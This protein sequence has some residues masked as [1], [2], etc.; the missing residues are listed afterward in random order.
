[1][2]KYRNKIIKE[3]TFI[4]LTFVVNNRHW[5]FDEVHP[6]FTIA[7]ASIQKSNPGPNGKIP[8]RGPYPDARSFDE[9]VSADPHEFDVES[10]KNWGGSAK[11]PLLPASPVSVSAFNKMDEM[12]RLS[13]EESWYAVPYQELNATQD[14]KKDDGTN[15][16]HTTDNPPEDNYWPVYK[17][18]SYDIWDPDRGVYY[19]WA[20]PETVTEYLHDSRASSYRYAGSRSPFS[21]MSQEWIES[22]DTLPCLSARITFRDVSRHTDSRTVR[23]ALIPPKTPVVHNS[24]T[25]IW[26]SGE[27]ADEA[28]LLGVLCSIP[29]DWYS[30]RF[31][32]N[33]VTFGVFNN[34]PIPRPGR[35]NP[36]RER[37]VELSGRLAAVDDRYAEWAEAVGVDCGPIQNNSKQEKIYELDA[38]VAH[39]Y[40]LSREHVEVIFETFHDGWD[41]EERLE[42]VLDYYADWADRLDLDHADREAERAAGTRNDD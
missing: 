17:G 26:P 2:E 34:L 14:K 12:N 36:L 19:G 32:E 5:M 33:H 1:M 29:L 3:G 35:D 7:L 4:D 42:R 21:E 24:P 28:Y 41:Y 10:A 30:R 23:A 8:L 6:Q 20:E 39:L 16:F 9:G 38:V 13:S 22:P 18:E 11:F 15:V 27:I 40:E 37:V 25:L 31:V